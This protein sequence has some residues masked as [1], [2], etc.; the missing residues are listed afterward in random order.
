LVRV[1]DEERSTNYS[2]RAAAARDVSGNAPEGREGVQGSFG[3]HHHERYDGHG[4]PDKLDG[5]NIPLEARIIGVA[6]AYEAMTSDRPYRKAP[7]QDYAIGELRR[8]AGTQFDPQAAEALCRALERP[9]KDAP[10]EPLLI[11][12]V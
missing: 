12:A 11:A 5:E 3:K 1:D 9:H 6:D 7:G 2:R 10:A 4:Y 8:H